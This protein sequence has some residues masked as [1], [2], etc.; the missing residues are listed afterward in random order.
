[1]ARAP[2]GPARGTAAARPHALVDALRDL[3]AYTYDVEPS[4][5]IAR[6]GLAAHAGRW[7]CP[8]SGWAAGADPLLPA[9]E[10]ERALLVRSYAA[11]LAAVHR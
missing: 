9:A 1:M 2:R 7:T 3:Y 6:R 10:E 4:A 5:L 8:T 11:L